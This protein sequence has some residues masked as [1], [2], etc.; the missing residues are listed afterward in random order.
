MERNLSC[1]FIIVLVKI[2]MFNYYHVGLQEF[3]K[4]LEKEYCLENIR[5]WLAVKD[6][7]EI[8]DSEITQKSQEIYE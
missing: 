6:F 4:Y 7:K 3:M 1:T 2:Y 8:S 5:F